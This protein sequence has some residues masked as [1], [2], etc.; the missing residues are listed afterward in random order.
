MLRVIIRRDGRE[1]PYAYVCSGYAAIRILDAATG[2]T[3]HEV[4]SYPLPACAI[5]LFGQSSQD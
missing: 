4:S 1:G 3:L 5:L 2:T